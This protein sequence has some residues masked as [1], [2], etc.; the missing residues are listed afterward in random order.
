MDRCIIYCD[1][2]AS[3]VSVHQYLEG[4]VNK[5][6]VVANGNVAGSGDAGSCLAISYE[7]RGRGLTRGSSLL[8]AKKMIPSLVV[9]ESCLP[10]YDIYAELYDQILEWIVPR[11]LFY[12][13]SCDEVV[14]C[15]E[16]RK[17]PVYKDFRSM[18]AAVVPM[19]S[20]KCG[21]DIYFHLEQEK[22]EAIDLLPPSIQVILG[23]SYLL[24]ETFL[25]ILGLPISIGI[26]PSICLAK[27]LID[28]AKPQWVSGHRLYKTAHDAIAFPQN[29]EDA[30]HFLRSRSLKDFCG[31][32]TVATRFI[33]QGYKT[34]GHVQDNCGLDDA[35]RVAKNKHLGEVLWYSVHGRDDVLP[36]YLSAIRDRK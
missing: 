26:A 18:I 8:H 19:L 35:I 4:G 29:R 13:G 14:I 22:L 11:E 3:F 2:N 31:V 28:V 12:R 7:A 24:R 5:P 23:L 25:Q 36:G 34:A 1:T 30:N 16:R 17:M 32:N 9:Y 33:D 15:Y 27:A 21:V 20:A 6:C 10:L